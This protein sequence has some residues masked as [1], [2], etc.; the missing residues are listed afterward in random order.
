M[1]ALSD[2]APGTHPTSATQNHIYA[3]AWRSIDA[4]VAALKA[5]QGGGDASLQNPG[6]QAQ[7]PKLKRAAPQP[8]SPSAPV[9]ASATPRSIIEAQEEAETQAVLT[10]AFQARH[11]I[12]DLLS[13]I[14]DP[15]DELL[16]T[17]PSSDP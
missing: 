11:A 4:R 10:A 16:P 14:R 8:K 13:V 7:P 3:Y 6:G 5:G 17:A 1:F 15:D 2:V 9:P 12:S